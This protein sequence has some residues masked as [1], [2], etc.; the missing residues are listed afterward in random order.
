[1]FW[2]YN[3]KKEKKKK[4]YLDQFIRLIQSTLFK[5]FTWKITYAD[6]YFK[7]YISYLVMKNYD[8]V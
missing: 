8:S 7:I 5:H 2:F 6:D 1:M 3:L 4:T